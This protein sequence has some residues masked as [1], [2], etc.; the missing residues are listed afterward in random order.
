MTDV[1]MLT[2]WCSTDST[3]NVNGQVST[4]GK[5]CKSITALIMKAVYHISRWNAVRVCGVVQVDMYSENL[6][7]TCRN[8]NL[9]IATIHVGANPYLVYRSKVDTEI[10]SLGLSGELAVE[11]SACKS[12]Q[13][14]WGG[15]L[16]LSAGSGP[17]VQ[18]EINLPGLLFSLQTDFRTCFRK[19]TYSS[20]W[21]PRNFS[22][23]NHR[24]PQGFPCYTQL[25]VD[26]YTH[27]WKSNPIRMM[28]SSHMQWIGRHT[29][30]V[31][32]K[33]PKFKQDAIKKLV[34][35]QLQ[36]QR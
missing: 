34:C 26:T 9:N 21:P 29:S 22:C 6:Q 17:V 24:T 11:C 32:A 8:R 25:L 12:A 35:A 33:E 31:G 27:S 30:I 16:L 4:T 28:D 19:I 3:L 5:D 10:A 2:G 20:T 23:S 36:W 13:L 18:Q 15:Q 1:D 14:L 7:K